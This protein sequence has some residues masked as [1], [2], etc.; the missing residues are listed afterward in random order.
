MQ[1]RALYFLC[2]ALGTTNLVCL[3]SI[4]SATT[5]NATLLVGQSRV[6][7]G[8]FYICMSGYTGVGGVGA[9]S[10]TGLTGGTVVKSISDTN[11]GTAVVNCSIGSIH[12]SGLAISGF[13]IDPGQAWITSITCNGVAKA[14]T[15]ASSFSY[16]SGT[17]TWNWSSDFGLVSKVGS[18]VSCAISH[19]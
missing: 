13:A 14:G 10:P 17:A 18:N 9:Y 2:I 11:G 16:S 8:L 12:A 4:S 15:A 1:V 6:F 19:P 7:T 3:P 5:D